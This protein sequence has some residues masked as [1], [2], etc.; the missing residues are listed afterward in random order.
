MTPINLTTAQSLAALAEL[1][2]VNPAVAGL[3]TAELLRLEGHPLSPSMMAASE[4]YRQMAARNVTAPG[5]AA[6]A[7]VRQ[8][9]R[10]H[11]APRRVSVDPDGNVVEDTR[12]K[13]SSVRLSNSEDTNKNAGVSGAESSVTVPTPPA[14]IPVNGASHAPTAQRIDGGQQF[15]THERLVTM[16][17]RVIETRFQSYQAKKLEI[18]RDLFVD[19]L[20]LVEQLEEFKPE[21]YAENMA[22]L[23]PLEELKERLMAEKDALTA[24]L[25]LLQAKGENSTRQAE[26]RDLISVLGKRLGENGR[27]I[28]DL[29][30]RLE[31]HKRAQPILHQISERIERARDPL[32]R[33]ML[34]EAELVTWT[35]QRAVDLSANMRTEDD[36]REFYRHLALASHAYQRAVAH[37]GES[38]AELDQIYPGRNPHKMAIYAE[39]ELRARFRDWMTLPEPQQGRGQ[40]YDYRKDLKRLGLLEEMG[41]TYMDRIPLFPRH[42]ATVDK[43]LGENRLIF[44]RF[45]D[46][47]LRTAISFHAIGEVLPGDESL[48]FVAHGVGTRNSTLDSVIE[49]QT[50]LMRHYGLSDAPSTPNRFRR[51]SAIAY[52]QPGHGFGSRDPRLFARAEEGRLAEARARYQSRLAEL[53]GQVDAVVEEGLRYN[54]GFFEE[55]AGPDTAVAYLDAIQDRYSGYRHGDQGQRALVYAGRSTGGWLAHLHRA[56]RQGTATAFDAYISMGRYPFEA[57]FWVYYDWALLRLSVPNKLR[58]EYGISWFL[59][60]A[61]SYFNLRPNVNEQTP[62]VLDAAGGQDFDYPENYPPTLNP[63]DADTSKWLNGVFAKAEAYLGAIPAYGFNPVRFRQQVQGMLIELKELLRALYPDENPDQ[64]WARLVQTEPG[65]LAQFWSGGQQRH[66]NEGKAGDDS[67]PQVVVHDSERRIV[68]FDPGSRHNMVSV[69]ANTPKGVARAIKT[70]TDFILKAVAELRR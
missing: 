9:Q 40:Y 31:F 70:M 22:L 23:R 47:G 58:N 7:L 67:E 13:F 54:E 19:V 4:A 1:A 16:G 51:L 2:V 35:V 20:E 14:R 11:V 52:A 15:A 42:D 24:E 17:L 39:H 34:Q 49:W 45:Y 53:S 18:Y 27:A 10:V 26:L 57:L 50:M 32:L 5:H 6:A 61:H 38:L 25:K 36:E 62:W 46:L 60:L 59:R 68:L 21:G 43:M 41:D 44:A 33:L 8:A 48:V 55:M 30:K 64:V 28:S 65:G 56:Q 37:D 66:A 63:E 3:Y 29:G 12:Q 69:Q